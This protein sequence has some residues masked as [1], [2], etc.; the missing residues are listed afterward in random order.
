MRGTSKEGAAAHPNSTTAAIHHPEQTPETTKISP[1]TF[2]G[3]G[4][5][6]SS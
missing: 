2:G 4:S 3:T 6:D 5:R 1:P